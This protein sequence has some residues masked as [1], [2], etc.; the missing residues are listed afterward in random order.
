[1]LRCLDSGLSSPWPGAGWGAESEGAG[2]EGARGRLH[3]R[4]RGPGGGHPRRRQRRGGAAGPLHAQRARQDAAWAC[5]LRTRERQLRSTQRSSACRSGSVHVEAAAHRLRSGAC[6]RRR[7]SSR[8]SSAWVA[9]PRCARAP[10]STP[11][12]Q[13]TGLRGSTYAA[14]ICVL[15]TCWASQAQ[16]PQ[17]R[18]CPSAGPSSARP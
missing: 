17:T 11:G 15:L 8:A 10:V 13:R 3:A 1:M 18:G 2:E 12:R 6:C 14:P 7:P 9:V 5:G 16:A 4:Q